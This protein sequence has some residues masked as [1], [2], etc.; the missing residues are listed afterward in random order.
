MGSE[1]APGGEDLAVLQGELVVARAQVE[2]LQSEAADAQSR[3]QQAIA[4]STELRE[5]VQTSTAAAAEAARDATSLREQL[6]SAEQRLRGSAER[7]RDLVVRTEPAL[8]AELIAGETIE[9]VD[10]SVAAARDVVGRVR[11]HIDAQAQ[12]ARVPA[13][14]P[15]RS[16]ADV[17][18]LSPEQKIRYGL[19]RRA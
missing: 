5:Q 6:A 3:A 14:A 11:A 8:P 7:Y 12:T 16:G 10:A 13:G 15:Q 2:R 17:S 4:E 19:E 9:D 18:A 1:G